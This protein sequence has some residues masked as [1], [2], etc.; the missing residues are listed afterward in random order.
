MDDVQKKGIF[1]QKHNPLFGAYSII[2]NDENDSRILYVRQLSDS[3]NWGS[4]GRNSYEVW[5]LNNETAF[6]APNRM[7]GY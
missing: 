4:R 2:Y 3:L 1:N 6:A 5:L 7:H